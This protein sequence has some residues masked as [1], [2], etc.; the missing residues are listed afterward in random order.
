MGVVIWKGHLPSSKG[1]AG[2]PEMAEKRDDEGVRILLACLWLIKEKV[3]VLLLPLLSS[4]LLLLVL[5][6]E[7]C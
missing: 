1:V 2:V 6:T 7:V 4:K 5:C 3:A